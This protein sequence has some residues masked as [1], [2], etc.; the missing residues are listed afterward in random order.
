MPKEALNILK[1]I[2]EIFKS[3]LPL[4]VALITIFVNNRN[5]RKKQQYDKRVKYVD[6]IQQRIME[7]NSLIWGAGA[8]I[9]EAIQRVEN[10]EEHNHYMECLIC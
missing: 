2:W 6:D 4:T 7:L 10:I 1:E 5:Q 9:L 8:D 3:L